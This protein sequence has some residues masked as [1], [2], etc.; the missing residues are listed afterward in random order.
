MEYF[1]DEDDLLLDEGISL[2]S[3]YLTKLCPQEDAVRLLQG[4]PEGEHKVSAGSPFKRG[5]SHQTGERAV[6]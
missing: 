1:E 3:L 6:L 5:A 2:T 4:L